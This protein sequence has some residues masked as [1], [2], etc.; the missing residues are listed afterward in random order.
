[1]E[2]VKLNGFVY[3]F[4]RF[5]SNTYAR[6]VFKRKFIRNELKGKKGPI[7]IIA[8]HGAALDFMNLIGAT[9]RK[10]NFVIS[11]SFY[12]TLPFKSVTQRFGLIPKQQ[13]QTCLAD[14]VRM[15]KVISAGGILVFYPAGLMSDDGTSTPIPASTYKFLKWLKADVY[16]ARSYGD[17]FNMPK[18]RTGG[19]RKGKT[20]IDV[21]KL[22]SKE[23]LDE[24]DVDEIKNQ[25][26]K[27]ML[28]DAYEEQEKLLY[29]YKRNSDITGLEN[30]LY[31]CP[32][33]KKEFSVKTKDKSVIYC[34]ECGYLERADK[35]QFLHKESD[36][37][38]EIRHP[39]KWNKIIYDE[40]RKKILSGELKEFSQDAKISLM[41][42][43]ENKFIALGDGNLYLDKDKFV[44]TGEFLGQ[45][46]SVTVP[47]STYASLA[48]KPGAYVEVQV[49]GDIYRCFLKDGHSAIKFVDMIE[50]FYE[51]YNKN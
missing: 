11:N 6:F 10:M 24:K 4:I 7:V 48:Y 38:E 26:E 46:Q 47:T 44:I 25:C 43:N 41:K 22:F 28:F 36:V 18:W 32:N 15:K 31:I 39:S 5:L 8:T 30:V 3:R 49:G 27:E 45:E 50:L 13:F 20:L 42:E 21:F 12:K 40:L 14:T 16:V 29:K 37:G 1:M 33:C 19:V 51:I 35:Y 9:K 34:E 17:Y 23:E 2:K